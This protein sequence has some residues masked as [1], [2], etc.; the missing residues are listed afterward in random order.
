LTKRSD[1]MSKVYHKEESWETDGNGRSLGPRNI[2]V[3][4][5]SDISMCMP[6]K[7]PLSLDAIE[8]RL[9]AIEARL[10]AI[11]AALGRVLALLEKK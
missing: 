5:T 10:D 1:E 9:D 7:E 4:D 3:L 11:E 8:A 2:E 6:K